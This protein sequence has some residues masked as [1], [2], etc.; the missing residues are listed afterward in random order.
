ML[1][2]PPDYFFK[3]F[4]STKRLTAHAAQKNTELTRSSTTTRQHADKVM[5]GPTKNIWHLLDLL[6]SYQ[7][8]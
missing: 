7:A 1:I 6:K 3:G 8:N 2:K 5:L 4:K